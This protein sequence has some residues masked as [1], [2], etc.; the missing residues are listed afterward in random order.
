MAKDAQEVSGGNGPVGEP[1]P[2]L[3]GGGLPLPGLKRWRLHRGLS[4][5]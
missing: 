3:R 4:Q 5:V 2:A 1:E